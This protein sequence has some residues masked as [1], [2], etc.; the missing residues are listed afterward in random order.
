MLHKQKFLKDEQCSHD[1]LIR[2]LEVYCMPEMA[3]ILNLYHNQL[4]CI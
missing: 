3:E 4:N 1:N 2:P